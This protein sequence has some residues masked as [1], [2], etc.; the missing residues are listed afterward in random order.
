MAGLIATGGAVVL[1]GAAA[2]YM[3]WRYVR[4]R[5]VLVRSCR[6]TPPGWS[7]RRGSHS[8]PIAVARFPLVQPQTFGILDVL[9]L[10]EL[11]LGVTAVELRDEV[12]ALARTRALARPRH[13]DSPHSA[14]RGSMRR[15][16][17]QVPNYAYT[18]WQKLY[19]LAPADLIAIEHTVRA[20]SDAQ[21]D[22]HAPPPHPVN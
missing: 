17:L 16:T 3:S 1:A 22:A 6:G 18:N 9:V 7:W 12:R 8:V 14:R 5:V 10:L 15:C 19:A 21:A 4:D 13:W 11:I 20:G 2:A